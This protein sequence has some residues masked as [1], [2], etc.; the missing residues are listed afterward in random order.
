MQQIELGRELR[1]QEAKKLKRGDLIFWQGHVAIARDADTI[2]HANAYHMATR[3]ENAR[4]AI[5]RIAAAGSEI[6]SIKRLA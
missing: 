1:P 2:V 5:T 4:E 3:I 6:T